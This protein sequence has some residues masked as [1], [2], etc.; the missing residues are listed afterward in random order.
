M[1]GPGSLFD[2]DAFRAEQEAPKDRR[3]KYVRISGREHELVPEIPA[4]LSLDIARLMRDGLG[5]SNLSKA[6]TLLHL[7][8]L[9]VDPETALAGVG[10]GELGPLLIGIIGLYSEEASPPPNRASR[11]ART[12]LR[13]RSTSSSAGRSSRPTSSASTGS[14]SAARSAG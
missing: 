7:E 8:Q 3:P 12:S 13:R 5:G 11:R 9:L 4:L 10:T 1:P 6:K 2:F 14:T